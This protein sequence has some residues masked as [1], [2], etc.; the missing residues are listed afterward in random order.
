MRLALFLLFNF[1]IFLHSFAQE[2]II[3]GLIVIDFEDS[4]AEGIYVTNSRTQKTTL[5]DLTG[6]F[7]IRANEGDSLLIR[8]FI[9]E[10]R[11]F[12]LTPQ[13]FNKE[14]ITIHLSMQPIALDEVLIAPKLTGYLDKDAKY[15]VNKDQLAKLYKE[16]GINPDVKPM[17][18]TSSLS[19]WKDYSPLSL[20]V[21][22]IF[23]SIT[24]DLKRKQNLYAFEGRESKIEYLQNYFGEAYFKEDLSIP[25]EKIRDF[26]FYSFES[27]TI[28]GLYNDGNFLSIMIEF[29]RLAPLYL[30]RLNSWNKKKEFSP[31]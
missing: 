28:P 7:S 9:Y 12:H 5:T 10:S 1:G 24:G 23:E 17:R 3:H 2:R 4:T 16:L 19:F 31:N 27:S 14:L 25:K 22:R 26:I 21:E 29:N 20:N 11:R 18:D 8:S 13:V 15:D 30:T 6:S